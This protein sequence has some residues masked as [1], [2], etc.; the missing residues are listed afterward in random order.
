MNPKKELLWGLG[1]GLGFTVSNLSESSIRSR[2]YITVLV[3][4]DRPPFEYW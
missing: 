4:V 2:V 1:V 3:S